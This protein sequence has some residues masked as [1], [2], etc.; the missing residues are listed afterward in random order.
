MEGEVGAGERT[1]NSLKEKAKF[2]VPPPPSP[3]SRATIDP[4]R[5]RAEVRVTIL[6]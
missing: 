3:L 1:V 6:S 4:N 2:S 5:F